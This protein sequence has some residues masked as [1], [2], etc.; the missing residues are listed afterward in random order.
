MIYFI[1]LLLSGAAGFFVYDIY[2]MFANA[3]NGGP[4]LSFKWL[5][6]RAAHVLVYV[7][8]GFL[9]AF[10]NLDMALAGHTLP[11]GLDIAL[12]AGAASRSFSLGILGPAGLRLAQQR[13]RRE[14]QDGA[15]EVRVE[16]LS[17]SEGSLLDY[18]RY[19]LTR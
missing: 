17:V 5:K 18:F 4:A 13:S 7:A 3:E 6:A 16:D 9:G 2:R 12:L 11:G 15:P 14:D 10:V 1:V 8:A 19:Y